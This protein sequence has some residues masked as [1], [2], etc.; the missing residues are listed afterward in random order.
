M[1]TAGIEKRVGA[2]ERPNS[3]AV[4]EPGDLAPQCLPARSVG[5][6]PRSARLVGVLSS[7]PRFIAVIKATLPGC[8]LT[9]INQIGCRRE[10]S[11]RNGTR[12]DA[13]I[14]DA[15]DVAAGPKELIELR[16][17]DPTTPIIVYCRPH[18]DMRHVISFASAAGAS[19]V[20]EGYDELR[21][22]LEQVTAGAPARR[23]GHALW[24]RVGGIAPH[25][26]KQ[27]IQLYVFNP[28]FGVKQVANGL[29]LD[30]RTLVTR[31]ACADWASPSII[32]GWC[33]LLLAIELIAKERLTQDHT[34]R[35]LGYS[36]SAR[37]RKLPRR[38]TD[39]SFQEAIGVGQNA[40][41][42]LFVCAARRSPTKERPVSAMSHGP[43]FDEIRPKAG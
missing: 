11:A 31:F 43:S 30:R 7:D 40:L 2:Y 42:E 6:D 3:C 35:L 1:Q 34:A 41:F 23:H 8:A 26:L 32:F 39:L 4:P 9:A 21:E 10:C 27:P 16:A 28:H 37:Q 33:R 13:L 20:I 25:S 15:R 36:G 38:L 12:I 24:S 18:R 19:V 29:Q 14:V 17:A 22:A 5:N